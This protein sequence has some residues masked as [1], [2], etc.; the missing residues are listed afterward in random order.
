MSTAFGE[1]IPEKQRSKMRRCLW[2]RCRA[3]P[4]QSLDIEQAR[5]GTTS[6]SSSSQNLAN[7]EG[8]VLVPA[9]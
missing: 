5:G 3:A 6:E 8:E 7:I 4:S 1:A 9:Q 2:C